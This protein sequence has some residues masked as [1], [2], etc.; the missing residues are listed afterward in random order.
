MQVE[1]RVKQLTMRLGVQGMAR[2]HNVLKDTIV[3]VG[4]T[5]SGMGSH[6]VG[7]EQ[8]SDMM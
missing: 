2:L 1:Q 5:V 7:S 4:F 6:L 3:T 8:R